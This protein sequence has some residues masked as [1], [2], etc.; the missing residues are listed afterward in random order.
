MGAVPIAKELG[1][2]ESTV[3]NVMGSHRDLFEQAP[4]RQGQV[5]ADGRMAAAAIPK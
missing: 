3:R 2:G 4:H 1:I 5:T